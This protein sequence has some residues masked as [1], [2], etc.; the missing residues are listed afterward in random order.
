LNLRQSSALGWYQ[1]AAD[2]EYAPA[3]YDIGMLYENGLGLAQDDMQAAK[4]YR[5]AVENAVAGRQ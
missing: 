2:C 3:E 5:R 1:E 4:W